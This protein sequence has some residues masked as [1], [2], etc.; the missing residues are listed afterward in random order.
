MRKSHQIAF[1]TSILPLMTYLS[2]NSFISIHSFG[3]IYIPIVRREPYKF[4]FNGGYSVLPFRLQCSLSRAEG[5]RKTRQI[6]RTA[7]TR[8]GGFRS[9]AIIS[10]PK[11]ACRRH[12]RESIFI[13]KQA[14][15]ENKFV[16][17]WRE[18]W[19]GRCVSVQDEDDGYVRRLKNS[20]ITMGLR[21]KRDILRIRDPDRYVYV[22]SHISSLNSN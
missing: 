16:G 10:R 1:G 17:S 5:G 9:N 11:S 3:T 12:P 2:K 4:G 8:R 7:G 19:V 20:G 15:S 21:N 13:R 14:W 18:Q 22:Y 6:R